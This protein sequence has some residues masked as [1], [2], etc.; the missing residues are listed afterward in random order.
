ME[1][2]ASSPT[3]KSGGR[4]RKKSPVERGYERYVNTMDNNLQ[5]DR[6]AQSNVRNGMVSKR[7]DVLLKIQKVYST[8]DVKKISGE[9]LSIDR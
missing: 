1:W 4:G 5:N 6:C 8:S 2:G 7:V 3:P 9:F